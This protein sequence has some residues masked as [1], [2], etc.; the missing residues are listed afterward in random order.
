MRTD[1]FD[2]NLP[3]ELIA[4]TPLEKR[5]NSKLMIID[6]KSG[7]ITHE[8]F[9]N[10]I[11]YLNKDDVL[12]LNDT[13]VM[14]ARIIGE[15]ND[16]SAIIELLL[17]KNIENDDW[18]CLAKPAKRI[19]EGTII[20]FGDGN[21]KATCI[22]IGEEGIRIMKFEYKGIFYEILD[23]LGSMPL[24]PYIK[25]KLEDKDRYQTVYAKN[26]GSSAAPTAGLH[27]TKELLTAIENKGIKI[28][29]ITLH[30]GLGTFR[31]VNVD[32]VTTHKMHSE[33]YSM[34][35]ETA[36]ILNNAK[37]NGKRIISVGTTSTRTLETI[38]TKNGK[39]EETSGW[40]DI[41]IYPGYKFKAIDAQITNFHLPKST[42]IM[43]VSAFATKEIILKAYEEAVRKRYRFFSFGDS[44]LIK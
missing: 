43:L 30:V 2:Y 18:E 9:S 4:Q 24:P 28:C 25:E 27:F 10:I 35:K 7:E 29:N 6:K 39:F 5:D 1:D 34:S 42:L 13:K 3:E 32:D 19:K 12:V 38:I 37:T 23:R 11:N 16:T 26:I 44:M 14:P 17:L 33:F 21:L 41:F 8:A 36:E 31:P 40:T 20:S 22:G 15:K